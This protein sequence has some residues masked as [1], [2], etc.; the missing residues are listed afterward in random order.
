[1]AEGYKEE[2]IAEQ[3]NISNVT[4]RSH[5]T[6]LYK[7]LGVN[8]SVSAVITAIDLGLIKWELATKYRIERLIEFKPEYLQSV[9]TILNYFSTVFE[10]NQRHKLS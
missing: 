6:L 9:I 7:R 8:N 5:K 4:I 1:M 2:D 3:L 10:P